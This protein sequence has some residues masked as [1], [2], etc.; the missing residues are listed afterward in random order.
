MIPNYTM[1]GYGTDN[2][3]SDDAGLNIGIQAFYV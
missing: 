1:V 2:G 3:K